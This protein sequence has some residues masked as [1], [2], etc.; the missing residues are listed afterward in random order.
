MALF[1]AGPLGGLSFLYT[2][3]QAAT[4]TVTQPMGT[5]EQVNRLPD[6]RRWRGAWEGCPGCLRVFLVP[7]TAHLPFFC[8]VCT[9]PQRV[10]GPALQPSQGI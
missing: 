7:L 3:I 5:A 9:C 1:P 6:S 4:D 2:A 10:G 8:S